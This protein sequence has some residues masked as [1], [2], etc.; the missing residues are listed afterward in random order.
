MTQW[1]NGEFNL[2]TIL[3][4]DYRDIEIASHS[5]GDVRVGIYRFLMAVSNLYPV[6][7]YIVTRN[8]NLG[9]TGSYVMS[10]MHMPNLSSLM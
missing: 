7:V 9:F 6:A 1:P 5:S 3:G 2:D 4:P 8:F 10:S